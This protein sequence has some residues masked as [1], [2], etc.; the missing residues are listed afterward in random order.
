M[1]PDQWYPIAESRRVRARP[2]GVR[3]LGEALVLWRD[4]DGEPVCMRDRCPHRGVALSRGRVRDGSLECPFHGFRFAASGHCV[5]MPC[6]GRD[7]RIPEG[8][9]V[10]TY[11][12]R[13]AHGLVWLFWGGGREAQPE[14]PWFDEFRELRGAARLSVEWPVNYVRGLEANFDVHHFPFVHRFTIPGTGERVDPYQVET[15]GTRIRTRGVLRHDGAAEGWPFRI[16]FAAPSVTLLEFGKLR[17]VVADCP[18]DERRTWRHAVYDQRYVTWPGLRWLVSW[19]SM[20]VDWRLFQLRQDLRVA[21]TQDPPLP[22]LHVDRL[23]RADAGTAA[24]LKLRRQ[25][26]AEAAGRSAAGPGC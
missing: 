23:V 18:V 2:L 21:E 1:I 6:E 8:M 11:P 16:E 26:L 12:L 19:L 17:F 7:A 24:Y 22:D 15:E 9:A 3:R 13:E 4:V 14:I 20:Q 25:L 10:P 5:R